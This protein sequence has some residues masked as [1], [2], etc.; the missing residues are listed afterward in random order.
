MSF[1]GLGERRRRR[2][3]RR[4]RRSRE[5]GL[6]LRGNERRRRRRRS[7]EFTALGRPFSSYMPSERRRRRGREMS[8][9]RSSNPTGKFLDLS[10]KAAV[11]SI[12]LIGA[13]ALSSWGSQQ[14]SR[15]APSIGASKWAPPLI[16][17]ATTGA[18]WWAG[19]QSWTPSVWRSNRELIALGAALH[20]VE[21]VLGIL[22]PMVGLGPGRG[23]VLGNAIY[24]SPLG[25]TAG[26]GA[27]GVC[28]HGAGLG[29]CQYGC[30]WPVGT[31]PCGM[32]N[33]L[34]PN[35]V[36]GPAAA[37]PPGTATTMAGLGSSCEHGNGLGTCQYG[38]AWPVNQS[39]C[40]GPSPYFPN[41]GGPANMAAPTTSAAAGAAQQS[42][43]ASAGIAGELALK[44]AGAAANDPFVASLLVQRAQALQGTLDSVGLGGNG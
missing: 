23:G 10:K 41:G 11:A 15:M 44:K 13:R 19:G 12:G 39:P 21:D 32:P 28:A 36:A 30:A 18:L 7:R 40:P 43:A 24:G 42:A 37:L 33:P 3:S 27:S 22:L 5:T 26:L 34:M 9:I 4:R 8:S 35:M 17:A 2:S 14:L 16:S 29:T 6:A 1:L 38:C 25:G 31:S 20:F